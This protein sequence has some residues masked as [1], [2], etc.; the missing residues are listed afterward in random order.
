MSEYGYCFRGGMNGIKVSDEELNSFSDDIG[1]S[2]L[3]EVIP[4]PY[5]SVEQQ[6]IELAT[7]KN[8]DD[9]EYYECDNGSHGWCCSTCGT[10]T[11]WG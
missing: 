2:A 7:C 4:L 6:K 9:A 1:N 10:V 3:D 8:H 11:Q 5:L